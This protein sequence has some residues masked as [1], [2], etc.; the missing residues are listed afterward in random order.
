[1]R[2]PPRWF[3]PARTRRRAPVGVQGYHGGPAALSPGRAGA[4]AAAAAV[5][6]PAAA[7]RG[8]QAAAPRLGPRRARRNPLPAQERGAEDGGAGHGELPL[9][10]GAG[11][12]GRCGGWKDGGQAAVGGSGVP[13]ASGWMEKRLQPLCCDFPPKP[14]PVP[15]T[16]SRKGSL[17]AFLG[18]VLM[19][20]PQHR[21]SQV[22]IVPRDHTMQCSQ[23]ARAEPAH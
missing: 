19:A 9:Q 8:R 6:P 20:F 7:P 1:M 4:A 22:S 16:C 21:L 10:G 18:E 5:Q 17:S 3:E 2:P 13:V 12:C 23:T 14:P 11:L 15:I